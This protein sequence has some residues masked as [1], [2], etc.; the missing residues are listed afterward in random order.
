MQP[1]RRI[2]TRRGGFTL[3]EVMVCIVILSI[4]IS[5]FTGSLVASLGMNRVQRETV[6]ARQAAQ[7]MLETM[8]G[9][10]FGE[11]F[12]AFNGSNADDGALVG[13]AVGCDFAVPGLQAIDGD[14][15]GLPGEVLFPN[16][17]NGPLWLAEDEVD[18][19]LGLPADLNGDGAIDNADHA[20]DYRLLP[21]R[22][23]IE[24]R[25]STGERHLDLET[26]LCQR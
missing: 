16:G 22:V 23:R 18:A 7:E 15:D 26:F 4:A 9:R 11:V 14:A 21:V 1:N 24:W 8:Q 20:A 25:S 6:L 13:A 17:G 12:A 3:I 5:G 10:T 19:A 2:S